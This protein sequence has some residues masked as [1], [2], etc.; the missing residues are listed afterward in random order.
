MIYVQHD[1]N[2]QVAPGGPCRAKNPVQDYA[3]AG[4]NSDVNLRQQKYL[5]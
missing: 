5:L 2:Q 1:T 4:G 3:Y